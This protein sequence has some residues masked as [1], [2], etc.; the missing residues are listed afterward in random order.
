MTDREFYMQ[1]WEAERP[2]MVRVF[3][4]L[5]EG[6]LGY[7]PHP[8]SRSAGELASLLVYLA[9]TAVEVCDRDR[10]VWSEPE[11]HG[12]LQDLIIALQLAHQQ[13][14][15]RFRKLDD[16]KWTTK[17]QFLM[18]EEDVLGETVGGIL[19]VSLLS[20]VHHRGQLSSYIRPMGGRV[21]SVYGPSDDSAE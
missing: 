6:K 5:P 15:D 10:I 9:Q 21:P 4:A 16:E 7:R 2:V 17:A 14:L 3:R 1:T 13:L 20:S 18:K 11:L 8:R 12:S 19:W